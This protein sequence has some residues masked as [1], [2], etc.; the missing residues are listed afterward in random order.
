[1]TDQRI[2]RC[3]CGTLNDPPE[4]DEPRFC[5]GCRFEGGAIDVMY[6]VVID[7]MIDPGRGSE[8]TDSHGRMI[9][10]NIERE[11]DELKSKVEEHTVANDGA[12]QALA[13]QGVNI[14]Q[15]TLANI[16]VIA[17]CDQVMGQPDGEYPSTTRLNFELALQEQY[18]TM[19]ADIQTQINRHKLTEGVNGVQLPPVNGGSR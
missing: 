12:L 10:L 13:R 17:L 9:D 4:L 18:A 5:T 1:M 6:N 19:L 15:G 14:D 8:V 16:R 2:W 3:V 7:E 11:L